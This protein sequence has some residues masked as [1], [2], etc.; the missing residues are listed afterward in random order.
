[1]SSDAPETGFLDRLIAH[2]VNGLEVARHGGLKIDVVRSPYSVV[3][4]RCSGCA[5]ISRRREWRGSP[6][7]SC[8]R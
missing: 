6:S 8:L 3:T 7:S 5:A 2:G 4:H 1:M